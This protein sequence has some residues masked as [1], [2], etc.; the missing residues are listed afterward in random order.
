MSAALLRRL[1]GFPFWRGEQ[2]LLQAVESIYSAASEIGVD[3]VIGEQ[4]S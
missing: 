1:G 2:P 3:L 4:P